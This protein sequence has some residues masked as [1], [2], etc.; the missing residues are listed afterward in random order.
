MGL[1]KF[2]RINV[3][4]RIHKL[5]IIT[6]KNTDKQINIL[7]IVFATF[8]TPKMVIFDCRINQIGDSLTTKWPI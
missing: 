7:L 4:K 2:L 1:F 3:F 5:S 6:K 8:A